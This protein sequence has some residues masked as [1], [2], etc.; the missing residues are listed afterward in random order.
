MRRTGH[1][2][3]PLH[4]PNT[5]SGIRRAAKVARSG[6]AQIAPRAVAAGEPSGGGGGGRGVQCETV[7]EQSKARV[8]ESPRREG[9]EGWAQPVPAGKSPLHGRGGAKLRGQGA[10]RCSPVCGVLHRDSAY[11]MA[12][13]GDCVRSY[14]SL[15]TVRQ[16]AAPLSMQVLGEAAGPAPLGHTS[17]CAAPAGSQRKGSNP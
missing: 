5:G 4:P 17:K 7:G 11:G 8:C 14:R 15:K 3:A 6:A 9:R 13:G 10:M 12:W 2:E 1:R 16:G